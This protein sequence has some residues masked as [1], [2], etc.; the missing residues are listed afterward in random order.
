MKS[1]ICPYLTPET[2]KIGDRKPEAIFE[3]FFNIFLGSTLCVCLWLST[4]LSLEP[5]VQNDK[6][7]ETAERDTGKQDAGR[8]TQDT[9]TVTTTPTTPVLQPLVRLF[10]FALEAIQ[11]AFWLHLGP[12]FF[13]EVFVFYGPGHLK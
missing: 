9:P 12:H 8:R 4:R 7:P 3:S 5:R 2:P 11:V 1:D 10:S 6:Y 13:G